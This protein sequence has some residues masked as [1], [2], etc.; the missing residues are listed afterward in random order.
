MLDS[1]LNLTTVSLFLLPGQSGLLSLSSSTFLLR[2]EGDT[3]LTSFVAIVLTFAPVELDE[4]E[5]DERRGGE[6]GL[7]EQ[8]SLEHFSRWRLAPS[9]APS[10][11]DITDIRDNCPGSRLAMSA[12]MPRGGTLKDFSF[13]RVSQ[14]SRDLSTLSR[15]PPSFSRVAM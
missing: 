11:D 6:R 13:A 3:I 14:S 15:S 10:D 9:P 12:L 1:A 5:D 4:V 2:G 7:P 8:E